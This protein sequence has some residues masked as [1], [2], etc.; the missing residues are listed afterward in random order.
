MWLFCFIFPAERKKSS[1]IM[2]DEFVGLVVTLHKSVCGSDPVSFSEVC[3]CAGISL[4]WITF[5]I[6]VEGEVQRSFLVCV[7]TVCVCQGH[8]ARWG[9]GFGR[10]VISVG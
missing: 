7:Y 5:Q 6:K 3:V 4:Q 2:S 1:F 8:T 9:L 10:C